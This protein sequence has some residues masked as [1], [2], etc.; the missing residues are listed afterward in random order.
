[1]RKEDKE[2]WRPF[3]FTSMRLPTA[4]GAHL[5]WTCVPD[6]ELPHTGTGILK[7]FSQLIDESLRRWVEIRE[8]IVSEL[9]A[10]TKCEK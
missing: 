5:T 10:P 9:V 1:M 4:R 7:T 3:L 8:D 6:R 2:M